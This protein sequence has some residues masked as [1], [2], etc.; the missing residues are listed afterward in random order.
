MASLYRAFLSYSHAAD[1]SLAAA[2]Q[3]GIQRLGKP[4][5]RRPVVR[6]FR[7]QTSLSAD[8]G[9]WSGIERALGQCEYFLLMASAQSAASPWVQKEVEWWLKHR[10]AASLL[11]IVSDGEIA[12][13]LNI[14]D[15]DWKKTTCLPPQLRGRF[16]EEPHYVDLRWARGGKAPSLWNARFRTAVLTLAAPLHGKAMDELDS[17]DIRQQRWFRIV[18]TAVVIVVAGLAGFSIME[19]RS[20]QN[21]SAI[22]ESRSM[23]AR[24]AELLQRNEGVDKAILVAVLAWRLSH[25]DEARSALEKLGNSSEEVATILGRHTGGIQSVAFSP[26]TNR[27][28]LLATGGRDGLIMLWHAPDGTV[29]GRPIASG[30]MSV[31]ELQFS[32]D[33]SY[34]LSI[35]DDLGKENN[36]SFGVIVLHDLKSGTRRQVPT[37]WMDEKPDHI[38]PG[39]VSLSPDGHLVAVRY[40]NSIGV[41]DAATNGVRRKL[42]NRSGPDALIGLRFVSNSRLMLV[43][44]DTLVLEGHPLLGFWDLKSDL[45]QVGPP[46]QGPEVGNGNTAAINSDGSRIATYPA[47]GAGEPRLYASGNDLRLH[48]IPFP[49]E[50]PKSNGE[51]YFVSLDGTGRRVAVSWN[52]KSV[53]LDLAETKVLKEVALEH[54]PYPSPIALSLDGRWLAIANQSVGNENVVVWD[55]SLQGSK[56]PTGTL[57]VSCSLTGN[58]QEE[59]IRRLC[60]K[61]SPS[62]SDKALRNALGDFDYERLKQTPLKEPCASR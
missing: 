33:G 3:R 2:L 57:N 49:G 59:C 14:H 41:W 36:R 21:E 30:Q 44:V 53:V 52:A 46:A 58:N 6:V 43:L 15:F 34:L 40:R 24:S 16:G 29:A 48:P 47:G 56:G 37:D 11:I 28:P 55:L 7:D 61:V 17:E 62:I 1:G 27:T 10:S 39:E 51:G 22:A 35:G 31:S 50:V 8:P 20:I 32:D 25:T 12:W 18:A 60:E 26:A 5:Y 19:Q 23:A 4:W 38:F 13:N 45:I 42:I 54:E 9:L